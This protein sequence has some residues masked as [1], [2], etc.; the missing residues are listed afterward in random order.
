MHDFSN[1]SSFIVEIRLSLVFSQNI[2]KIRPVDVVSFTF[3]VLVSQLE[4]ITG[5][6]ECYTEEKIIKLL[7]ARVLLSYLFWRKIVSSEFLLWVSEASKLLNAENVL[8]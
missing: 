3:K 8:F 7:L 5:L 1:Y 2:Y 4:K 6:T